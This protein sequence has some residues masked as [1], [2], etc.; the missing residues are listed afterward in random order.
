MKKKLFKERR[1][2]VEQQKEEAS[3]ID[4]PKTNVAKKVFKRANKKE[5]K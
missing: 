1:Y 5:D 4:T 2:T 3:V